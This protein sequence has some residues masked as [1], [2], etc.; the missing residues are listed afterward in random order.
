MAGA[1]RDARVHN[2]PALIEQRMGERQC[3]RYRKTNRGKSVKSTYHEH[4][5]VRTTQQPDNN[6]HALTRQPTR[7]LRTSLS[8]SQPARAPHRPHA[9]R[10]R[11][12]GPPAPGR[13]GGGPAVR[14]RSRAAARAPSTSR[15]SA[16]PSAECAAPTTPCTRHGHTA[17]AHTARHVVFGESSVII[18]LYRSTVKSLTCY[19]RLP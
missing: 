7:D 11:A 19:Y 15:P 2:E 6:A 14:V 4:A 3:E 17:T 18:S 10:E 12:P 16:S 1:A 5:V 9:S 13:P 8:S